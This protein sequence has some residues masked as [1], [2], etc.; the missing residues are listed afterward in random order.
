[1][2]YLADVPLAV[3]SQVADAIAAS[4]FNARQYLATEKN[5]QNSGLVNFEIR[6]NEGLI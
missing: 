5:G 3:L 4:L 1:M 2:A 6:P